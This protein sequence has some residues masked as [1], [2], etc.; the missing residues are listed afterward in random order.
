[1]TRKEEIEACEDRI[2]SSLRSSIRDTIY[3]DSRG[4]RRD[5]LKAMFEYL[6]TLKQYEREYDELV[7]LKD[8]K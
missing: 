6:G 3:Y 5:G 7:E 4:D 8:E 1:M 2:L